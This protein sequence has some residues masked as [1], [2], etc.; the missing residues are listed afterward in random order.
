MSSTE[1]IREFPVLGIFID[2]LKRFAERVASMTEL[3]GLD[4]RQISQIASEFGVSR[5]DL[6]RLLE[7]PASAE[8]LNRRLA[9]FQ[10]SEEVLA[11]VHPDVLQDLQRVCG[12]CDVTAR[13]AHDFAEQKD[14]G[15]DAYCPNT[16]T[17]YALKQEGLERKNESCGC[18]SCGS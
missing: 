11:K 18:G 16:C 10:L 5:P 15:R 3:R 6:F 1:N 12:T 8:L 2:G 7:N 13:C 9:Q 14:S 17:L 4:D